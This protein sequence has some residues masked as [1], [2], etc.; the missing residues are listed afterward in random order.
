MTSN[1][2]SSA[3]VEVS[4]IASPGLSGEQRAAI[5]QPIE[6]AAGL[7]GRATPVLSGPELNVRQCW[8]HHGLVSVIAM[9]LRLARSDRL[10]YSDCHWS[11]SV[12]ERVPHA[13]FTMF[14][15]IADTDW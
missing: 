13:F 1:R 14:A 2:N 5:D 11:L 9:I 6:H 7:P 10:I 12:T 8:L 3:R 15:D 4:R